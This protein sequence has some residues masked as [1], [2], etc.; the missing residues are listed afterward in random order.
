MAIRV[1]SPLIRIPAPRPATRLRV[2]TVIAG[3]PD[4][5]VRRR[6]QLFTYS[7]AHGHVFPNNAT[8]VRWKW[9]EP[10]GMCEFH[11]LELGVPY[12]AIA[13]DHT[14][15]YAPSV[16]LGLFAE[17]WPGEDEEEES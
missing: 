2:S 6:V 16:Q 5:P 8:P 15:V 3:T 14:G 11:G 9:S 7:N 17:A 13:Y 1:L 4:I 12:G 10:D